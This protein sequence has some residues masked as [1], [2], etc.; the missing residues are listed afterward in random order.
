[1]LRQLRQHDALIEKTPGSF[2]LRSKA[3]LHFHEHPDGI[4][5]D[6]KENLLTF[7]RYRATIPGECSFAINVMAKN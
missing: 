5:V 3:L 6:L 2:Y 7:T 1:V 4:F